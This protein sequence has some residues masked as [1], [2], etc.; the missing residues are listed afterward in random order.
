MAQGVPKPKIAWSRVYGGALADR[1][2]S[3]DRTADGGFALAGYTLSFDENGDPKANNDANTYVV[4]TDAWGRVVWSKVFSI[5]SLS[6]PT[7]REEDAWSVDAF[8]DGG[9]EGYIVGGNAGSYAPLGGAPLNAGFLQGG[10]AMAPASRGTS[11]PGRLVGFGAAYATP[12]TYTPKSGR[13]TGGIGRAAQKSALLLDS[14]G[15]YVL[16]KGTIDTSSLS[17]GH[18]VLRL[19]PSDYT[20]ILADGLDLTTNI[21]GNFVQPPAG[22]SAPDLVE[23]D[24]E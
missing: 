4:K 10:P 15:E 16:H 20:G 2:R 23:F 1:A 9:S 13:M 21:D 11:E 18:Y 19:A 24:V 14:Q 8:L 22:V 6:L 3:V 12:W 7:N 5:S 17:S